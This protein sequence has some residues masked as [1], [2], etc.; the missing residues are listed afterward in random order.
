MLGT[1]ERRQ[2]GT[3]APPV[4]A[5]EFN[6]N[7]M[8]K[9]REGKERGYFNVLCQSITYPRQRFWSFLIRRKVKNKSGPKKESF[10]LQ[11]RHVPSQVLSLVSGPLQK[12]VVNS[13]PRGW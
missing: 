5:F 6:A 4:R 2:Q 10:Q 9:G 13:Y 8:D 12:K 3:E 11:S 7:Q 1:G